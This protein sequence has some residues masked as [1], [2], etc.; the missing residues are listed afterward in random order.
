MKIIKV[1]VWQ[2]NYFEFSLQNVATLAFV[3]YKE[4]GKVLGYYET[5]QV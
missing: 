4:Y 1:G 2:P 5:K 3:H